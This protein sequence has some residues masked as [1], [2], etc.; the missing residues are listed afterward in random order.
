MNDDSFATT[1]IYEHEDKSIGLIYKNFG[2]DL[3]LKAMKG[4]TIYLIFDQKAY[5]RLIFE[6]EV[7]HSSK[8]F[9]LFLDIVIMIAAVACL[10]FAVMHFF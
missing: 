10:V 2:E 5:D 8:G 1:L 4:G 3:N 9:Y 6:V 7:Q